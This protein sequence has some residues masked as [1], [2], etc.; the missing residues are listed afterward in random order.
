MKLQ[1]LGKNVDL[2]K[3]PPETEDEMEE[4]E[5]G[6]NDSSD[7]DENANS[8]RGSRNGNAIVPRN[9][10]RNNRRGSD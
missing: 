3:T 1:S 10:S 8:K 5:N 2:I 7:N 4:E 6:A 9:G